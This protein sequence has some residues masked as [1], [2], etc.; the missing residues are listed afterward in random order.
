MT[1]QV[2]IIIKIYQCE[3][4]KPVHFTVCYMY[5]NKIILPKQLL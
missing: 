1:T 4:L 2:S 5:V 3:D